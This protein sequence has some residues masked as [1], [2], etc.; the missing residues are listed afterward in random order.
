[1]KSIVSKCLLGI[2]LSIGIAHAEISYKVTPNLDKKGLQVEMKIPPMGSSLQLEMPKWSPGAYILESGIATD[3]QATDS[4]GKTLP[5]NEVTKTS[6]NIAFPNALP[7]A[8]VTVKYFLSASIVDNTIHFSG[9]N[10]YLY[11]V[12]RKEEPCRL[13]LSLPM[14]WHTA[15]GIDPVKGK[16]NEYA[17]PTYDVLADNPV[18]A[19]KYRELSYTCFGKLHIIAMR[20]AAKDDIDAAKIIKLCRG[21]S[22]AEGSFF[23]GAPYDRYVWHFS[24]R[25]GLDGGGGLEHLSS[26]EIGLASGLGPRTGGLLAHEF[27]HLWNVKRIR[28]KPLGPFD[29]TQLPQTGALWWLEGVTDYYATMIPRRYGLERDANLYQNLIGNFNRQGANPERLKISPYDSSFKVR[30]SNGGIGNSNGLGVSYYD[31]G[32]LLGFCLD[33]EILTQTNGKHSLDDVIYGLWNLCRDNQ[34]GF[35]EDE[36]RKQ[37]VKFG[38]PSLGPFYDSLVMKPGNLP[39]EVQLAK[40]GLK[41]ESSL[42]PETNLGF[43]LSPRVSAK[44]AVVSGV[45]TLAKFPGLKAGDVITSINGES[46]EFSSIR[47]IGLALNAATNKI[48]PDARVALLV[49]HEDSASSVIIRGTA[50]SKQVKKQV[51]QVSGETEETKTLRSKW[52]AKRR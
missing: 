32:W 15:I 35:D 45:E 36:I 34:P 3:L 23:G 38:G 30:E 44:G 29:Y 39:T 43:R 19:G 11:V 12:G 47:K 9:P 31:T 13:T 16:V 2:F 49:R 28:S 42:A 33:S 46:L 17:A 22:E 7:S 18:T 4:D 27:F 5:V 1:M 41:I 37:C 24:V 52:L 25:D 6:W 51:I 40:L 20:G 14:G 48:R 21:I 26:T 10:T 8:P 50:G